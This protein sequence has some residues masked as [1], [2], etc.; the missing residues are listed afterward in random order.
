MLKV[1]I[2]DDEPKVRKVIVKKGNW[3]KLE[4][5][6]VAQAENG[7]D[8][9][10]LIK[11]H[12]PNIVITDMKMPGINGAD[13]IKHI[14]TGYPDTKIIIIS[15]FDDFQYMK[16]AINSRVIDYILKPIDEKDLNEALK[17]GIREIEE[18]RRLEKRERYIDERL[19]KDSLLVSESVFNRF[20]HGVRVEEGELLTCLGLSEKQEVKSVRVGLM[21]LINFNEVCKDRYNSDSRALLSETAKI[22][23]ELLNTNGTAIPVPQNNEIVQVLYNDVSNETIQNILKRIMLSVKEH[24]GVDTIC[25]IGNEYCGIYHIRDSFEEAKYTVL[26]MNLNQK[27]SLQF[28]SKLLKQSV[29]VDSKTAEI[30]KILISAFNS[31]DIK[32]VTNAVQN[33]YKED[34][35]QDSFCILNFSKINDIVTNVIEYYF[36]S[37]NGDLISELNG[38]RIK[39]DNAWDI[40]YVCKSIEEFCVNNLSDQINQNSRNIAFKVRDYIEKH[41]ASKILLDDIAFKF[42]ISKQHLM[43]TF[44][45][46]FGVSPYAYF[47]E[48]KIRKAKLL[49]IEDRMKVSE[50]VE[51][52]AFT[53]E[54]HFSKMFKKYTGM[55]PREFKIG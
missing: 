27:C 49:L 35:E 19:K 15:G 9:C 45:M 21:R 28:Y 10:E 6:I 8:L 11:I 22:V 30:E 39:I 50:I 3:D 32:K 18:K 53:D 24:L 47:M 33:I 51:A 20:I 42:G 1:I 40:G 41:Y 44:K 38:L 29:I 14:S 34:L 7:D 23:N 16:Q 43:K 12:K 25:G 37:D 54:S 36:C 46:Q 4:L 31:G 55:T 13:L 5:E 26:R 52:L 2:A 48:L 17:K